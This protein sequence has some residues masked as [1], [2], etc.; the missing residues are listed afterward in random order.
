MAKEQGQEV[1]VYAEMNVHM[2]DGSTVKE[3]KQVA[4]QVRDTTGG[5][6]FLQI[7]EVGGEQRVTIFPMDSVL[8]F[9]MVPAKV[10]LAKPGDVPPAG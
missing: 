7:L 5:G 10:E 8:F 9:D 2:A 6:T 4:H 1:V 3:F